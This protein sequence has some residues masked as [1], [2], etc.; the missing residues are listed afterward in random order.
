MKPKRQIFKSKVFEN[1]EITPS[2]E[3]ILKTEESTLNVDVVKK[4]ESLIQDNVSNDSN[5]IFTINKNSSPKC[6]DNKTKKLP[7]TEAT[8]STTKSLLEKFK[9]VKSIRGKEENFEIAEINISD[10]VML[11]NVIQLERAS[12]DF[13]NSTKK[14]ISS[15]NEIGLVPFSQYFKDVNEKSFNEQINDIS[16][17]KENTM[18]KDV[19]K[20]ISITKSPILKC[21]KQNSTETP[22]KKKPK[23]SSFNEED[24]DYSGLNFSQWLY[25]SDDSDENIKDEEKINENENKKSKNLTEIKT[26]VEIKQKFEETELEDKMLFQEMD[27]FDFEQNFKDELTPKDLI[28]QSNL[29]ITKSC[30]FSTASGR[31]IQINKDKLKQAEKMYQEIEI[32]QNLKLKT[33]ESEFSEI[34]SSSKENNLSLNL[35]TNFTPGFA[36]ARGNKI[37]IS[38]EKLSKAQKI[39]NEIELNLPDKEIISSSKE[40]HVTDLNVNY[41]SGFATAGGK[42]ITISNEKLSNAQKM[43]SEIELN[44]ADKEA[45]DKENQVKFSSNQS[46]FNNNKTPLINTN[47]QTK[48]EYS[49]DIKRKIIDGNTNHS[50]RFKPLAIPRDSPIF[51]RQKNISKI[52]NNSIQREEFV[53][54]QKFENFN[55]SDDLIIKDE[56]S[57]LIPRKTFSLPI[58]SE[59]KN[60]FNMNKRLSLPTSFKNKI[61]EPLNPESPPFHGFSMQRFSSAVIK[62]NSSPFYGFSLSDM[63]NSNVL[64]MKFQILVEKL[65][66]NLENEENIIST[67]ENSNIKIIKEK[68]K[69]STGF[70]TA[71]GKKIEIDSNFDANLLFNEINQEF[72]KIVD[73]ELIIDN[74]FSKIINI[75]RKN[76][77]KNNEN[78]MKKVVNLNFKQ[79]LENSNNSQINTE[80]YN[81]KQQWNNILKRSI[82]DVDDNT[83]LGRNDNSKKPKLNYDFHGKKLFTESSISDDEVDS[84]LNQPGSSSSKREKKIDDHNNPSVLTADLI[85]DSIVSEE[86]FK[87]FTKE[88]TNYS[89]L[90]NDKEKMEIEEKN[91]FPDEVPRSPVL[92][93][94]KVK[95]RRRSK[96][97][98]PIINDSENLKIEKFDS[99]NSDC[100][101]RLQTLDTE[102]SICNSEILEKRIA[103]TL[104]LVSYFSNLIF[105]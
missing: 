54:N 82:D 35:K 28:K 99:I 68:E 7:T 43:Y 55:K 8:T 87:P 38:Q 15:I 78:L 57:K 18:E 86:L 62:L 13:S 19:L 98:Q 79:E 88:I 80:V 29:D 60:N 103:A 16:E 74:D 97:I 89:E 17:I 9:E 64:C 24:I 65:K 25:K 67:N 69:I 40:N 72:M 2:F 30:G 76:T 93:K 27:S 22:Q 63:S 39:Y 31:S 66:N 96:M 105:I 71:G 20:E 58:N 12:R 61:S 48:T 11:K 36:T 33:N 14:N 3:N 52:E 42:K 45:I 50:K 75:D 37:V 90:N 84:L 44:S 34:A 51:N 70:S 10:N 85:N 91:D 56:N 4:S 101:L 21:E 83:P 41:N 5:V 46:L 94:S 47:I 81:R 32:N 53:K 102:S 59:N 73:N 1:F 23:E 6:I 77:N 95:R 100:S 92:G 26:N 104:E 49:N